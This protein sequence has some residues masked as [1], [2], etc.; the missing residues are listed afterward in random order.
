[1]E[2]IR[3]RVLPQS[4]AMGKEPH[5]S[6][7]SLLPASCGGPLATGRHPSPLLPDLC[8]A[9]PAEA[10]PCWASSLTWPHSLLTSLP[11][12]RPPT[13]L[14]PLCPP[15][16]GSCV[17]EGPARALRPPCHVLHSPVCGP[18]HWTPLP[19]SAGHSAGA[20]VDTAAKC[21]PSGLGVGFPSRAHEKF[22]AS[23][24]SEGSRPGWRARGSGRAKESVASAESGCSSEPVP[25]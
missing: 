20:A 17:F 8:P 7:Q 13:P 23:G 10:W 25:P 9:L 15:G 5:C 3:R 18:S 1:M 4:T 6:C 24:A 14:H 11:L 21:H 2:S 12:S 22:C 16:K 19:Q